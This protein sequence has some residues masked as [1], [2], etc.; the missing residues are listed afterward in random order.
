MLITKK[1][2]SHHVGI[3]KV[4]MYYLVNMVTKL[5]GATYGFKSFIEGIAFYAAKLC[6]IVSVVNKVQIKG[7]EYL[8]VLTSRQHMALSYF[9]NFFRFNWL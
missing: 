2:N 8:E 6:N 7:D 3:M 4:V 5:R 9:A 1:H